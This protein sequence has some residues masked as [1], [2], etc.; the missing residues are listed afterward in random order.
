MKNRTM[1]LLA[2]WGFL[3]I[4]IALFQ[5]YVDIRIFA[6]FGVLWITVVSLILLRTIFITHHRQMRLLRSVN[7]QFL[8]G[9]ATLDRQAKSMAALE[10]QIT[11]LDRRAAILDQRTTTL[12]RR[13]IDSNR[14]ATDLSRRARNTARA[15]DRIHGS[16]QESHIFIERTTEMYQAIELNQEYIIDRINKN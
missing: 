12:D 16:V 7:R 1:V 13:T 5:S 15:V 9:R 8:E 10:R 11:A 6:C 14:L 4:V 3:G 2:G